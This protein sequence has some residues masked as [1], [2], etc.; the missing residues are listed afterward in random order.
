[1]S[2]KLLV[3]YERMDAGTEETGSNTDPAVE[4][5]GAIQRAQN[6]LWEGCGQPELIETRCPERGDA[7]CA[8]NL[9]RS[10][11]GVGRKPT[12]GV[13]FGRP[14]FFYSVVLFSG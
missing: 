4:A 13:S 9:V 2:N 1:M 8:E 10:L 12:A 5:L 14:R 6:R 7:A 11:K 3:T